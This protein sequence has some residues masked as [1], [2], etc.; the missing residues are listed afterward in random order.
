MDIHKNARTTPCGRMLM[1]HRLASGGLVEAV[2]TPH[3]LPPPRTVRRDRFAAVVS[4]ACLP[5]CCRHRPF[6]TNAIRSDS[7]ITKAARPFS[8]GERAQEDPDA[9]P[10]SEPRQLGLRLDEGEHVRVELL[11]LGLGE[12]MRR[13]RI[14]L[15]DRTLDDLQGLLP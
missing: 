5:P 10:A 13:A 4:A 12:T 2:A 3:G 14:D 6:A 15:E 7:G 1:V 9:A 8:S 11:G